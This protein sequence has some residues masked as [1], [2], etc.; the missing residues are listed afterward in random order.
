M[1]RSRING[2]LIDCQ[3]GRTQGALGDHARADGPAFL[4]RSRVA[5]GLAEKRQSVGL[6]YQRPN[7]VRTAPSSSSM[8]NGFET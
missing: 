6:M 2:L 8:S 7:A 3:S 1:H 5:R 4:H